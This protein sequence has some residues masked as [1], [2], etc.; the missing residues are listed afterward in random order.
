M[1]AWEYA[2][3]L[4]T[5]V[6][7]PWTCG[8]ARPS[9][10]ANKSYLFVQAVKKGSTDAELCDSF[11]GMVCNSFANI[12]RIRQAYGVPQ[13]EPERTTP[14]EVF[15][16]W[17][18]SGCGKSEFARQQARLG[19]YLPYVLPIGKD[20][21]LTPAMCGKKYVIIE[22][23]KSNLGLKDLLNL[24]DK[25]PVEVPIKGGF[26]WW[27]PDIVVITTNR[28][29][30]DWYNYNDRD[31]EKTAVF[32]RITGAYKFDRNPEKIP[33]PIEVDIYNPSNFII[34]APVVQRVC[35]HCGYSGCGCQ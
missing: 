25:Y 27:M 18:P 14:L 17:G 16:F 5:R 32:R 21:W 10:N 12:Q 19:G 29:P 13:A 24:L 34:R 35:N 7:G 20:F 22:D 4:E 30:H 9:E 1:Q 6:H 23:F 3:K 31:D 33:K 26:A 8:Q 28:S 2:T 11:P 15:L